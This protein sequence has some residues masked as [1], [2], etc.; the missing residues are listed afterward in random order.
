MVCL[1]EFVC[2]CLGLFGC[3]VRTG[4]LASFGF[5]VVAFWFVCVDGVRT[6]CL[7][8]FGFGLVTF[9]FVCVGGVRITMTEK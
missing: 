2:V 3:G 8:L 7:S 4:C 1:F 9:W 6:G 5:I